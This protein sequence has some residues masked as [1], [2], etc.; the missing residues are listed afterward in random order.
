MFSAVVI[1]ALAQDRMPP[2]PADKYTEAQKKAA[3]EFSG[4][5]GYE[6]RGPFVP[7]IRSPEVMLRA[8]A[9]GDHLRFNSA[10][11]PRLSEMII[12]ITAREWTQQYEWVAHHDIA[13]KAGLRNDIADAIADGR[14]PVGMAEDEEAAYDMSIEIQ[15]TKRVSDPTWNKAVAKFGEQ[16]VIDLLGINGYY[17]FLA[18][19]MNAARTGLPAGVAEPLKRF[20]D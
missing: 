17:T 1:P 8:K 12:L 19:A 2:I 11:A 14:R 4:G 3:E 6:V 20:P 18:M 9:M 13:I 16:G 5:R 10:L 7:L 15:R